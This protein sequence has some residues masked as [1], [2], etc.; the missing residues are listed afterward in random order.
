MGG[1]NVQ[2]AAVG[3]DPTRAPVR[4]QLCWSQAFGAIS[5]IVL[6]ILDWCA[7]DVERSNFAV[8]VEQLVF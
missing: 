1:T 8:E 5:D 6:L 3:C 2:D 4:E 7:G